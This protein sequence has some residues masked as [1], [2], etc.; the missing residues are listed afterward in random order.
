M[1]TGRSFPLSAA[2]GRYA[3]VLALPGALRFFLPAAVA[4]L[5]VAV[6]G[7]AVLWTVQGT[8]G[9]FAQA[10]AA[11]GAFALADAAAGPHIARLIDRWGQRPVVAVS[12]LVFLAAGSALIVACTSSSP[13]TW[14]VLALAGLTGATAPPVGALAA[15]RWRRTAEPTGLLPAAFAL[16]GS[17]NDLTFLIGPLLVTTLSATVAPSAGLVVALSCVAAGTIGLLTARSSEPAPSQ[18]TARSV[19]CDPRLLNR[20]FLTLFVAH[21]ATGFFFGGIGIGI[22]AFALAHDAGALAGPIATGSSIVSLL[23]GLAYGGAQRRRP[24]ETMLSAAIVI[25]IGCALLALV[26]GVPLM[27]LGYP[28]VGGCVALV[29]IPAS[30]LLQRATQVSVYTQAMTW[31]NS[32]SAAGIAASASIVGHAIQEWGWQEGFLWL[33]ALTALLPLTLVVSY[34]TLRTLQRSSATQAS[35]T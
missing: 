19:L 22:T 18:S 26:P 14:I 27:F 6:T 3:H 30:E 4:R 2:A 12:A 25:T 17:L 33:S 24:A 7:V 8:S 15:A 20:G 28:I 29:L 5:G 35:S 31:I 10:G 16:E 32:A 13:A 21:L 34:R 9:S 23:A 1:A 11:T